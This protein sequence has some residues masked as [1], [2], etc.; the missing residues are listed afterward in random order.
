MRQLSLFSASFPSLYVVLTQSSSSCSDRE[1]STVFAISSGEMS[2]EDVRKLFRDVCLA[3]LPAP[4]A[5]ER[6]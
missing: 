3:F 6:S 1:H 5:L 2:E 4:L